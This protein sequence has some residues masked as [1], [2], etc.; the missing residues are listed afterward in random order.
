MKWIPFWIVVQSIF[1][2]LCL[3]NNGILTEALSYKSLI[4]HVN[5]HVNS[6]EMILVLREL[7][8][9]SN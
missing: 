6:C 2:A 3:H 8:M 4:Q 9:Q 5:Q 1:L 7:F